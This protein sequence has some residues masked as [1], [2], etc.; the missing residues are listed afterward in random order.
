[1]HW[2][3]QIAQWASTA[4]FGQAYALCIAGGY[5]AGIM[6]MV[7][8]RWIRRILL[9]RTVEE[10]YFALRNACEPATL[11]PDRPGNPEYMKSHARDLV[12][13]MIGRL[14]RARFHPPAKC[15]RSDESLAEWFK[16]LGNV[17]AELS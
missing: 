12:N 17:R 1:M 4:T 16:F 11:D 8:P 3:S 13:A 9:K 7:L 2:L 15:D 14:R 10:A 6:T 5:A